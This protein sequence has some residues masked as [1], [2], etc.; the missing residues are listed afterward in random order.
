MKLFRQVSI[1]KRLY[2]NKAVRFNCIE[3]L[4]TSKFVLLSADF[5]YIPIKGEHI[6]YF[7]KLFPE[8]FIEGELEQRQ[9]FDSVEKA[10]ADHENKFR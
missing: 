10:V 5:F 7:E 8:R 2:H 3:D 1:W 9:W 6:S 4:E